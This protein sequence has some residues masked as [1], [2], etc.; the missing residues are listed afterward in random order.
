MRFIEFF[1]SF[2]I[3]VILFLYLK[4]HY[5]EVTYVKSSLDGEMYLV[6]RLPDKE[7]AADILAKLAADMEKLIK[8]L[9]AKYPDNKDVKRL[10]GNFN[11]RHISEGS[12]ESNYTSYSVDKGKRLVFCIRQKNSSNTFV[13]YNTLLYVCIHELAHCALTDIGH[14]PNFWET[15]RFLLKEAVDIGLYKKIDYAQNPAEFCG[16]KITSSVI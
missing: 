10:Y 11:K 16:I 9:V 13:E 12:P 7:K 14:T 6:R 8:H 5:A 15:F 2:M 4:N 3:I 1:L